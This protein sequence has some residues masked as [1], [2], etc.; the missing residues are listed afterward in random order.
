MNCKEKDGNIEDCFEYCMAPSLAYV[1]HRVEDGP[2]P[3][4]SGEE[5]EKLLGME[6]RWR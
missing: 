2:E 5:V 1:I 4:D 6:P 3:D